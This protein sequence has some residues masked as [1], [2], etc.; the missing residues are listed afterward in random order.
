MVQPTNPRI[1]LNESVY[2]LCKA[3]PGLADVLASLGFA[4][5]L[6]PGMLQ[7]A[8]R[9][10]TLPKGAALKGIDLAQVRA[11]LLAQGYEVVP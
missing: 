8:G 9:F 2:T 4:D 11:T 1:D 6:R 7:S 3:H 5:I 10:M